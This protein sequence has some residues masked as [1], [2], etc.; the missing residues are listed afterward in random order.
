MLA[1][2]ERLCVCCL[3]GQGLLRQN[4]L[5][6]EVFVAIFV[7]RSLFLSSL[8]V[9]QPLQLPSSTSDCGW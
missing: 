6:D 8:L 5:P 3:H 9:N 1:L 7:L 2:E 4:L